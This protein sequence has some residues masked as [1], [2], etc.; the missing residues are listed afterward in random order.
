MYNKLF[1]GV[2]L[3]A[4]TM[5]SLFS[6]NVSAQNKLKNGKNTVDI[7]AI[8]ANGN[9]VLSFKGKEVEVSKADLDEAQKA[10]SSLTE[11]QK[12]K[13]DE[14]I[15]IPSATQVVGVVALVVVIARAVGL[16]IWTVTQFC[17]S[18][19]SACLAIGNG[20]ISGGRAYQNRDKIKKQICGVV[21]C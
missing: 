12:Q 3:V 1:T 2:L 13:L 9:R 21:R 15:A 4:F 7:T 8:K 16:G 19:P 20:I 18:S 6:L 14:T 17:G 10:Y 5:S 11:S